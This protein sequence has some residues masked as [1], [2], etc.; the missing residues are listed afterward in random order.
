[1]NESI[2]T[3]HM[4]EFSDDEV[5]KL[6]PIIM[7]VGYSIDSAMKDEENRRLISKERFNIF[8]CITK[9]HKEELHSNILAYLL[10]PLASHD[11]GSTFLAIFIQTLIKRLDIPSS[12][13][14]HLLS[15]I[16]NFKIH[17]EYYIGRSAHTENFGFID[18]LL[19]S[20]SMNIAIENKI[21]SGER[22]NQ[23]G[24][25]T[26]HLRQKG[27]PFIFLYLTPFGSDS[28]ENPEEKYYKISYSKEITEW[29]RMCLKECSNYPN[30]TSGLN[31]YLS[32]IKRYIINDKSI[33]MQSTI[34]KILTSKENNLILK[35]M[36]DIS[37]AMEPIRNDSRTAFFQEVVKVFKE[38]GVSLSV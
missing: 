5:I 2:E 15:E 12:D 28:K 14:Q 3:T 19:E 25:Y 16:N 8:S 27:K 34:V 22:P 30:V 13:I 35:Y 33:F 9:H 7:R 24:R 29:L 23:I 4:N 17:P 38:R 18:I 26:S 31:N 11:C 37:Q 6:D 1:M 10:D 36:Q 21:R 32:L 20:P